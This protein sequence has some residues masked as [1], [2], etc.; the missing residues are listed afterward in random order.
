MSRVE[1]AHALESGWKDTNIESLGWKALERAWQGDHPWWETAL[2]EADAILLEL[3]HRLPIIAAHHDTEA[4]HVRMFRLPALERLQHG[5][6]AALVAQRYGI[7]GLRTVLADQEAPIP[8]RYFA[9]RALAERHPPSEWPVFA[10]YLTPVAHHAFVGTAAEA[11]RFYPQTSA[12]SRLVTLFERV[13][14]DIQ[15]RDFLGPRILESL[16]V[17]SD[18]RTVGFYRWLLTAGFVHPDPLRCEVT[19]ALVMVRR[20]TG[21]VEANVKYGG[22]HVDDLK[23]ILRRAERVYERACFVLTPVA[24]I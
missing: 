17:L 22:V 10:R 1:T 7:A 23:S 16:F 9:F 18:P 24:V 8:R 2:E 15:L 21:N 6:A 3:L 12:A 14:G 19:H 13:A 20:F 11:A 5:T 4:A